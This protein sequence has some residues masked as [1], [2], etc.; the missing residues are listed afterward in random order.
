MP[1]TADKVA[2]RWWAGFLGG[3]RRASQGISYQDLEGFWFVAE[4]KYRILSQ[5]SAE[6][7]KAIMQHD[8]NTRREKEGE[9][10]RSLICFTFHGNVGQ[11]ARRFIMF[12]VFPKDKDV[13]SFLDTLQKQI[14]KTR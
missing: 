14:S 7:R 2:E 6:F 4:H 8:E 1:D 12:E 13:T 11:N 10:R 5:Y 3:V 9:G